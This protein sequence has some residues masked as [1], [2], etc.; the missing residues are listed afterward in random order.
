MEKRQSFKKELIPN[1]TY[2]IRESEKHSDLK[3]YGDNKFISKII[4]KNGL[5]YNKMR[6]TQ[7]DQLTLKVIE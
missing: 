7:T 4:H 2:R 6:R 5:C 1:I 3:N